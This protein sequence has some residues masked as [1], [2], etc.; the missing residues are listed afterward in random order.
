MPR[1]LLI[2]DDAAL[3]ALLREYLG[4]EGYEV[5]LVDGYPGAL[6]AVADDSYDLIISDSIEFVPPFGPEQ[7]RG[8][9]AVQAGAP[10]IPILL[11]TGYAEAASLDLSQWGIAG[12]ASKPEVDELLTSIREILSQS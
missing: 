5:E 10:G 6:A 11:F 9:K 1:L 12:A 2:E 3:G 7:V 4:E 8:L